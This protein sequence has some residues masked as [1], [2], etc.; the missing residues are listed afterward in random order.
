MNSPPI[1]PQ[2]F[3]CSYVAAAPPLLLLSV[4][5]V[6]FVVSVTSVVAVVANGMNSLNLGGING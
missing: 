3:M 1:E 5:T 4:V 2:A 6:V